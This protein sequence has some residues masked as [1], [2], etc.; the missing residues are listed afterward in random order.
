MG[1]FFIGFFLPTWMEPPSLVSR[2]LIA[3]VAFEAAYI[4]EIVRGGLQAVPRGQ[5]EAAQSLGLAPWKT[6]RLVVLPQALRAVIPAMVGQFI[7]LFKDTSLLVIIGLLE[8]LAVAQT[9]TSQPE[10]LGLGLASVTLPYAAF[11]YW[12]VSYSMSRESRLLEH[13]LGVGER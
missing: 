2:A 9:V 4:A 8:F 1:Q 13:R 7:S 5:V 10:F 11:G 6:V 3:I 12:A